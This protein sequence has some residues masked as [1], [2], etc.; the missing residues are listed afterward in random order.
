MFLL[1]G[2]LFYLSDNL[3]AAYQITGV[4]RLAAKHPAFSYQSARTLRENNRKRKGENED[5]SH[6]RYGS[7]ITFVYILWWNHSFTCCLSA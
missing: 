7:F 6:R 5:I 3:E 4:K 1:F 2:V